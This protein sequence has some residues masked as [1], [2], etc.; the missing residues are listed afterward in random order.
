MVAVRFQILQDS[1]EKVPLLFPNSISLLP[2]TWNIQQSPSSRQALLTVEKITLTTGD[3]A[4]KGFESVCLVE[5]K[6]AVSEVCKNCLTR[7]GRRKFASACQRLSLACSFPVLLLEGDIPSYCDADPRTQT[8]P[9]A[10]LDALLRMV[11][12][13]GLHLLTIP[14]TTSAGRYTVGEWVARLLINTALR[15]EAIE[16][17]LLTSTLPSLPT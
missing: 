6:G 12:D 17:R 16:C 7:E 8:P 1:R 10:G 4:L 14:R 15:K 2:P 11:A 3:Y 9:G 13:Y 5:R